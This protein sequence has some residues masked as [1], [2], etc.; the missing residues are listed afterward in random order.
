M[1]F[2]KRLFGG[3][4]Q[5]PPSAH[6]H[7]PDGIYFYVRAQRCNAVVKVRADKKH[8]LNQAEGGG[9]VWHKTI[10]DSKCFSRM[11]A[12]VYFDSRYNIIDQEISAGE[13]ITAVEYQAALEQE[14]TKE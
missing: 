14:L 3:G 12:V 5:E 8:D 2:L 10:V 6:P 1:N 7:D 13:F 9:Y 4:E 11:Q